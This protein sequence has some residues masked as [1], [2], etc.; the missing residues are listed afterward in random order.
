MNFKW[1]EGISSLFFIFSAAKAFECSELVFYRWT[2][3][4]LVVV[5]FVNNASQ[6]DPIF[7]LADH[8]TIYSIGVSYI[9]SFYPNLLSF[10]FLTYEYATTRSV[11]YTAQT[12]FVATGILSVVRTYERLDAY[13]GHCLLAMFLFGTLV[14]KVRDYLFYS[15]MHPGFQYVITY[16]WHFTAMKVLCVA[17]LT[18]V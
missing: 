9:N 8:L 13:D 11:R 15:Q 7:T 17:S 12:T 6:C 18:A 14:F 2:N 3:A 4:L 16:L 10:V 5:S 1:S